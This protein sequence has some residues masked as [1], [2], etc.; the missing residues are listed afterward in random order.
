MGLVRQR[1]HPGCRIEVTKPEAWEEYPMSTQTKTPEE[2]NLD[3]QSFLNSVRLE[4]LSKRIDARA[5]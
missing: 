1:L 4:S 3:L 5:P 2:I